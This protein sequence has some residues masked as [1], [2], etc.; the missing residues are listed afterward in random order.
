MRVLLP[1]CAMRCQA[2]LTCSRQHTASYPAVYLEVK[3]TQLCACTQIPLEP[4]QPS[5]KA[6][7]KDLCAG[8]RSGMHLR[9]PSMPSMGS[10]VH[11]HVA[12]RFITCFVTVFATV[13]ALTKDLPDVEGDRQHGI[14]TF[15]TMLGAPRLTALG[16]EALVLRF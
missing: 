2:V 14:Q 5:F 9:C 3:V 6:S 11:A 4:V 8:H 7:L 1:I 12:R 16:A 15:A 13:I 10:H